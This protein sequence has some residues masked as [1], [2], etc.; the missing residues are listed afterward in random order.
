MVTNIPITRE[1]FMKRLTELCLKSGLTGFPKDEMSLHIL[2]KSAVLLMGQ[3]DQLTEKEVNA[4]LEIWVKLFGL[5]N[6][7]HAFK[8]Y[9]QAL[10]LNRGHAAVAQ[11]S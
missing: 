6:H 2:L 10:C 1:Y 9:R 11:I 8:N 7:I 5:G 3:P 4:K